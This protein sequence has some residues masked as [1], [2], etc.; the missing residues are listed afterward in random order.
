[1]I[2]HRNN[3]NNIQYNTQVIAEQQNP[4][5]TIVLYA[6]LYSFI[7]LFPYVQVAEAAVA[8]WELESQSF[9]KIG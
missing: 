4:Q 5:N 2:I 1:M 6:L 3:N 7:H 8:F 9:V